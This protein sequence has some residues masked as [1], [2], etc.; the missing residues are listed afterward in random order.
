[1]N[2][3]EIRAEDA[4]PSNVGTIN[5]FA[6]P[7]KGGGKGPT[8]LSEQ[9]M[10]AMSGILPPSLRSQSASGNYLTP[11]ETPLIF[12]GFSRPV[13]DLFSPVFD[14][15]GIVAVQGGAKSVSAD[16][17]PTEDLKKALP[18]GSAVS[19][20]LATGDLGL[21]GTGTVTYNDGTHILAFGHPF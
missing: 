5:A 10:A 14:R 1:E 4:A 9:V 6:A 13:L 8:N 20:M 16:I 17:S 18:P 3:M 12:S 15:M 21:A 2:M 19:G 11:I 7:A